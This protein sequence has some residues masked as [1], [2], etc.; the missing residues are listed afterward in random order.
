MKQKGKHG[1]TPSG[2]YVMLNENTQGNFI[3]LRYNQM[4]IMGV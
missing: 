2:C 3:Y 1:F 4:K